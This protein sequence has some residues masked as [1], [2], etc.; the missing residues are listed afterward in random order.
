MEFIFLAINKAG[1][2]ISGEVEAPNEKKALAKLHAQ[3]LTVI[4]I[5][6][7]KPKHWIFLVVQPVKGQL[8]ALFIR[9][10]SVML[11]A[12][13]PMTTALRSLVPDTGPARYKKSIERLC[14]D[15][16]TGFSL[17]QA[18]RK[19]P[20]YFNNFMIGS[21]R[22]GEYTGT[23]DDTLSQCADFYERE[24][25]YSRKL[26]SA[27]IYPTILFSAAGLLVLFI[28]TYMI[29]QFVGLFVDLQVELPATTQTLVD[30]ASFL[31]LYGTVLIGTLI[32]P[33]I[34]FGHLLYRWL[35]TGSGKMRSERMLLALPWY[36]KQ[37]RYRM[38]SQYF[39]AL[40]TLLGSGV[41]VL[42]SLHLLE[43]SLDREMLRRTVT[44]QIRDVKKGKHFCDS[45]NVY[46][47]FEP[48]ALEMM[49]VGEETGKVEDMLERMTFYYDEEMVRGLATIGKLVEPV[50]LCGLGAI[51]AF[52]LLAA[53]QPI[54]QLAGSF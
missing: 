22:I 39:R 27:L 38:M 2:R 28:F 51:V 33:T 17:S 41:P 8:L 24:Y 53:F 21:V 40:G 7:V 1:R 49:Q 47:L 6:Q 48:M 25:T 30:V 43:I 12:G 44:H 32:G 29:P 5:D 14:H 31:E 11:K 9:Q 45:L 18:M 34:A 37:V 52:L 4:E 20:E 23:L 54:Y 50:V 16:E 36:G 10:L 13:I 35:Q 3:N 26:K 15:V 46:H 19:A 42:S